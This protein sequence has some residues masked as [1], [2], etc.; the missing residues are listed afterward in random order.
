MQFI[1][2]K[3][4]AEINK[5]FILLDKKLSFLFKLPIIDEISIGIIDNTGAEASR[6]IDK[7]KLIWPNFWDLFI[8]FLKKAFN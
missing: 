4:A 1:N 2:I 6:K 3:I 5:M 8:L 7:S